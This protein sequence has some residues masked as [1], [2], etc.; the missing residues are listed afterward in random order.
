MTDLPLRRVFPNASVLAYG[1]MNIGGSW[2]EG[3]LDEAAQT[4]ADLALD[5]AVN[6]G[7]TVFDHADIYCRGKSETVFGDWLKRRSVPRERLWIQSKAGIELGGDGR[8][9]QYQLTPERVRR[10][11]EQSLERLAVDYL[12]A[13]MIH[14]PD[15]LADMQAVAD[16]MLLLREEGK[17][18]Y[19]GVSNMPLF[20]LGHWE[21][22]LGP[23]LLAQQE[24]SLARLDWLNGSSDFNT[25]WSVDGDAAALVACA[26]ERGDLQLQA[27]GS[28]AQR[29]L[30]P[31]VPSQESDALQQVM[32]GM[33]ERY[34]TTP[35]ALALAF[36]LRH[37]AA[38]Q[39]LIGTTRPERIGAC[40]L[41]SGIEL[42]RD[43][44]YA[45][46]GAARRETLP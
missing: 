20:Q 7:I 38:I 15:P 34:D 2:D 24:M 33:M 19:F 28:A 36:L 42:Q 10:H 1:C 3:G 13:W 16:E 14:R 44:W 39:P 9:Y 26:Q 8:P 31:A 25:E 27:W 40:A 22:L 6:V 45:L 35:E 32:A 30:R 37:P 18:R 43:D 23:Q 46:Y 4:N 21:R 5:A 17:L 29:I 41:S 11:V 12:D